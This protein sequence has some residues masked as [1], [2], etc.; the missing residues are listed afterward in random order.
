MGVV[1]EKPSNTMSGLITFTVLL[2]CASSV[3]PLFDSYE[4]PDADDLIED[5]LERTLRPLGVLYVDVDQVF[6]NE[7]RIELVMANG[8]IDQ[9][10]QRIEETVSGDLRMATS[11][12]QRSEP[13]R[14]QRMPAN[15]QYEVLRLSLEPSAIIESTL[16]DF[17]QSD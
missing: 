2:F 11:S 12:L 1:E 4:A 5:T 6:R 16:F 15:F 17:A 8:D 13:F 7:Y 3:T 10:T 9:V 14:Y